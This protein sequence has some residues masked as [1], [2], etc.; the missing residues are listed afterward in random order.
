MA[1]DNLRLER[2]GTAPVAIVT[3]SRPRVRNALSRQTFDELE[4][5]LLEVKGDDAIRV[6]VVTGDGDKAFVAGADI[7]ELSVVSPAS[8]R[9]FARAGQHVFDLIEH[10][11]KPVIAA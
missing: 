1:F 2:D 8:G 4:R 6:L 3:I 10:L 7:N 5:A 9:D 11:G